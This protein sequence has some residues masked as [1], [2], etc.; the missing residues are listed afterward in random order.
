M[1]TFI[2]KEKKPKIALLSQI[3]SHT[4]LARL[5]ARSYGA[6]IAS[7]VCGGFFICTWAHTSGCKCNMWELIAYLSGARVTSMYGAAWTIGIWRSVYVG[8]C[9][10]VQCIVRVYLPGARVTYTYGAAWTI[11]IW[12]SVYA[13]AHAGGCNV[14]WE[15]IYL[16]QGLSLL[17]LEQK[18][19]I[20][21]S[22]IAA[23]AVCGQ[24]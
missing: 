22:F 18:Y 19:N 9:R 2:L 23:L 3:L 5:L 24:W 10:W 14:L 12:R 15:F 13:W 21:H 7:L 17:Q 20:I 6:P 8:T 11:E 16:V 4:L 1:N